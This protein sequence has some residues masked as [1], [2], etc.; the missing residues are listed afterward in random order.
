MRRSHASRLW[1]GYHDG[2]EDYPLPTNGI[3]VAS[4]VVKRTFS[5]KGRAI[6]T[7]IFAILPTNKI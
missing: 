2:A 1:G 4:I 5:S 3:W 6:C 7:I